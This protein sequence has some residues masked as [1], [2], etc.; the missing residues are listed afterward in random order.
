MIIPE[1]TL[2]PALALIISALCILSFPAT[3]QRFKPWSNGT[4]CADSSINGRIPY[5]PTILEPNQVQ[6]VWA[7]FVARPNQ[8]MVI[9]LL[10]RDS[11]GHYHSRD[12]DLGSAVCDGT[13]DEG[14]NVEDEFQLVRPTTGG[15]PFVVFRSRRLKLTHPIALRPEEVGFA[16]ISDP[17]KPVQG[18]LFPAHSDAARLRRISKVTL[19][20]TTF[21]L[22][23]VPEM[24]RTKKSH[25]AVRC[26]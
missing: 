26:R 12:V 16:F 3:A 7:G 10:A 15:R 24:P 23:I 19:C 14:W 8:G 1:K 13:E 11:R 21:G 4:L 6:P 9:R 5:F 17:R 22:I 2:N 18:W 25:V 20:Y